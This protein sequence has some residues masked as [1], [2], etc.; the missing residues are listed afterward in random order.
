MISRYRLSIMAE[1]FARRIRPDYNPR[2]GHSLLDGPRI[3]Q[4]QTIDACNG[5]C[6]SCPHSTNQ[7]RKSNRRMDSDL[8]LKLL[9][10]CKRNRSLKTLVLMLQNEPIMDDELAGRIRQARA[11][12]GKSIRIFIV[13]NGTL[14]SPFR[15]KKLFEAGL[16]RIEVSIDAL[17]KETY[18]R[19]RRGLDFERVTENTQALIDYRGR[20]KA[21]VRF[22][23]QK[24]NADELTAFTSYWRRKGA[25]VQTDIVANRA[26]SLRHF[27]A[28]RFVTPISLYTRMRDVVLGTR[29]CVFGP[30][31]RLTVLH[32]G[33]VLVC[34]HDWEHTTTLGDL[35]RQSLSEV[36]EGRMAAQ[37][38]DMLWHGRFGE[39]ELCSM[40]SNR[41]VFPGKS[42]QKTR[43][44]KY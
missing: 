33:R 25:T 22:L 3:I 10:D 43:S 31:D 8:Y 1:L 24:G 13:T 37:Y 35:S 23:I 9:E 17:T 21:V 7:N 36:W 6:L 14:L 5:L 20:K 15:M 29:P 40:C 41:F 28:L 11:R 2:T 16:D 39:S 42:P 38:R 18:A 32:D 34:C 19:V 30:F 4:I 27:D 26:G 44:K 12:L